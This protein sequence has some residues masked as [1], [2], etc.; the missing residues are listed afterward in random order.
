MIPEVKQLLDY[1]DWTADVG[2]PDKWPDDLDKAIQYLGKTKFSAKA[3]KAEID[4]SSIEEC[5]DD[6]DICPEIIA[7]H[8]A[9]SMAMA[10]IS[11]FIWRPGESYGKWGVPDSTVFKISME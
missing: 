1:A 7:Q 10:R 6:S 11:Q 5:Y 3:I 9:H 2:H 4:A 8:I